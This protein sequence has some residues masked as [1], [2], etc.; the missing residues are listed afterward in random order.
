MRALPLLA[1]AALA[2]AAFPVSARAA[3][4]TYDCDTA[5][6]HFSELVLPAPS[7]PFTVTGNLQLRTIAEVKKW[8]PLGRVDISSAF[9]PGASP[10]A[11]A[12]FSMIALPIDKRKSPTGEEVVQALKFTNRGAED[13]MLPF[14]M[15]TKPGTVQ[16]FKLTYSGSE[17]TVTL[18]EETRRFPL[19][20]A[21]PVVR[22]ICSTGEF[23]FTDLEIKPT[24]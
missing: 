18:G 17:V 6:Q 20:T 15:L 10:E 8:A 7:S 24:L 5:S 23:L 4:I 19:K 14:S 22:V 12:G 11:F 21:E 13:E 3:G 16:P 2:G 1:V 9:Q